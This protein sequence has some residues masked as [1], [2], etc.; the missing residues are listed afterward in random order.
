[1]SDIRSAVLP[2]LVGAHAPW[3]ILG[4]P[5][6]RFA[7][8]VEQSC[9]SGNRALVWQSLVVRI[10]F[11][12]YSFCNRLLAAVNSP[13]VGA[14]RRFAYCNAIWELVFDFGRPRAS[15]KTIACMKRISSLVAKGANVMGDIADFKELIGKTLTW[16]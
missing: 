9:S 12:G 13:N 7:R 2:L 15:Q 4:A 11:D 3:T 10:A 16:L 8:C 14:G 5:I 6:A 1:M